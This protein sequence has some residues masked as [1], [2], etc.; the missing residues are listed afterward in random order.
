MGIDELIHF[1]EVVVLGIIVIYIIG[2]IIGGLLAYRII[3]HLLEEE[4]KLSK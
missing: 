1:A 3:K 4:E 2:L